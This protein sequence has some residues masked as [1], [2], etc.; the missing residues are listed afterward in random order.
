L[1]SAGLGGILNI[2]A[3]CNCLVF[4]VLEAVAGF[5]GAITA[6]NGADPSFT[7]FGKTPAPGMIVFFNNF[8]LILLNV[9]KL[10]SKNREKT[11]SK[12]FGI[13]VNGK[14]NVSWC[15]SGQTVITTRIST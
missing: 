5:C 9:Y 15:N 1:I 14:H 7:T 13:I 4:L 3:C 8:N 11:Y 10:Y 2:G 12:Q 6:P